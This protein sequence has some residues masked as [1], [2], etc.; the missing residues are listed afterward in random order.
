MILSVTSN[1]KT[2]SRARAGAPVNQTAV[3]IFSAVG[4]V[5]TLG[6]LMVTEHNSL[7]S[8]INVLRADMTEGQTALRTDMMGGQAALRTDMM[9]GQAALR[10]DMMGGQAALRADMME[11]QAALRADMMEGQAALRAE[12]TAGDAALR[13]AIDGLRSDSREDQAALRAELV[14]IRSDISDIR[15]TMSDMGE[16][17]ARIETT[18]NLPGPD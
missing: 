13:A 17:V 7:R 11:G 14:E 1:D 9:G 12:M 10:A 2:D 5:L 15:V 4:V 6:G 18:L 8:E 16:R 3:S